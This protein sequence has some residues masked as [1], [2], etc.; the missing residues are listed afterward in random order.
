MI[1]PTPEPAQNPEA[2]D[3]QLPP[4][5]P[6]PKDFRLPENRRNAVISQAEAIQRACHAA[7]SWEEDDNPRILRS[8]LMKFED[9][10]KVGLNDVS[11]PEQD[12]LNNLTVWLVEMS[13]TFLRHRSR[14]PIPRRTIP[15]RLPAR[16]AYVI[17]RA[18]D[19]LELGHALS[20]E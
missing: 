18:A 17:L 13:G 10:L 16:K 11:L 8:S 15:P 19:G 2:A 6:P 5:G 1:A 7:A 14:P 12:P 9:A 3:S 20:R 4:L